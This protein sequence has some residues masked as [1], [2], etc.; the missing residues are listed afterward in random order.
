MATGRLMANQFEIFGSQG[1]LAFNFTNMNELEFFSM[2]DPARIRGWRKINVTNPAHPY[3]KAWWPA[4]HPI[5]YEHTFVHAF[6]NFFT[7]LAEGKPAEPTFRDAAKVQAVMEAIE[8]SDQSR[9]WT[10]VEDV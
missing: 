4:G 5:G 2:N 7:A 3:M 9:A 10:K 1:G 6:A 8:K